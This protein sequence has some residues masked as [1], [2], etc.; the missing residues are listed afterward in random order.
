[1]IFLLVKASTSL[2]FDICIKPV[3]GIFLLRLYSL[4]TINQ[5]TFDRTGSRFYFLA[6]IID[7]LGTHIFETPSDTFV[8]HTDANLIVHRHHH[9]H[10]ASPSI[11]LF[12]LALN[13]KDFLVK[14]LEQEFQEIYKNAESIVCLS[15]FWHCYSHEITCIEFHRWN[16]IRACWTSFHKETRLLR[17]W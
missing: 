17:L 15:S 16:Q 3:T 6:Y 10:W 11:I 2:M 7:S 14:P 9:G 4:E 5:F 1:M 12:V 13:L 8:T